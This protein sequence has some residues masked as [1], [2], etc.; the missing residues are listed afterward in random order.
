MQHLSSFI[1]F[2]FRI[3][4]C[5]EGNMVNLF[6]MSLK[7]D[8]MMLFESLDKGEIWSGRFGLL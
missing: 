7:G 2:S 1:E 4:L 5:H 8:A 6:F 3:G